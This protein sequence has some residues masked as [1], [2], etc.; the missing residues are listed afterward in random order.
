[1][2]TDNLARCTFVL[3]RT[4]AHQLAY[5]SRRFGRSR[6]DLVRDMLKE[7][8]HALAS[9]VERVPDD[10][11]PDDLRQ[12]ALLGLD[13]VEQVADDARSTLQQVAK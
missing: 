8:V 6:S 1:M 13:L 9:M 2:N 11:T 7:P 12:L 5:L 3:D 4:T 10:P